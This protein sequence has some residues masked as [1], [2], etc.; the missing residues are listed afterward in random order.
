M[1]VDI[2]LDCQDMKKGS[3]AGVEKKEKWRLYL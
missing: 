1:M 2:G 3:V